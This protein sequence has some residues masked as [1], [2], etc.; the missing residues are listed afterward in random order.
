MRCHLCCVIK[1]K[2]YVCVAVCAVIKCTCVRARLSLP[3]SLSLTYTLCARTRK[4]LF[5]LSLIVNFGL[6]KTA[7]LGS[8]RT[9]D[10]SFD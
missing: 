8:E 5:N 2:A 3:L 9:G 10:Y 1:C 4:M 6:Y 7:Q